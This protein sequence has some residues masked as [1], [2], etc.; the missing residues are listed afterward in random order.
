MS[1]RPWPIFAGIDP[2]DRSDALAFRGW[3]DLCNGRLRHG[4]DHKR[5][6]KFVYTEPRLRM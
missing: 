5:R 4:A 6:A 1:I 3:Y 2:A